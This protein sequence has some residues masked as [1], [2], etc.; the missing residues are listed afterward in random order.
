MYQF[1][2]HSDVYFQCLKEQL[3]LNLMDMARE[4]INRE[5]DIDL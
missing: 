4:G 3:I 5:A 2:N 1:I